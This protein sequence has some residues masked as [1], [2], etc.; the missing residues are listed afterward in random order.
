M[1]WGRVDAVQVMCWPFG[2][3]LVGVMLALLASS[4]AS[5]G[6]MTKETLAQA[7]PAPLIVGDKDT[8]LPVWPI[9]KQELTSTPLIG[10]AFES[11]D[12]APIPGFSGTPFNLLVALNAN[13]DFMDVQVLSQHEPVFLEGLGP[14]PMLRFVEQY[15]GLSLKQNIKIGGGQNNGGNAN[16]V[17]Q[18]VAKATASVRILNQ[19]LLSSSLK[20]A[21]SK[22]G[23]AQGRDPDLIAR[24]KPEV[25][26]NLDWDK[27][28]SKG[29]VSQRVFS[30]RMVNAAF[31]GT[32]AEDSDAE[33]RAAPDAVFETLYATPLHVPTIG[34]NL[35]SQRDWDYLQGRLE[36]GDS[37]LLVMAKGRYS[38]LGDEFTRGAV[39]SRITLR[40]GELPL[41]LRDLD[42]DL[43]EP[44]RVPDAL[45]DAEWKIFRVIAPAGLDPSLPLEFSLRVIRT[46]GEMYGERVGKD[47]MVKTELPDRYFEAAQSDNKTWHSLWM[48]RWWE[49]VVLAAGLAVLT[50]ALLK[51]T[52]LT[53]S[54]RRLN[55]F[56]T[57]YMLFT[58]GFIGW[59][60]QGQL[61]IVNLTG[62]VRALVEQRS[63]GFFLYDPMTVLLWAFT[64]VT[65]FVWGRGTFC[66]WLCPFGALQ[67]LIG[68][69]ARALKVPQIRL[70]VQT[71]S[72]LKKLKYLVLAVI[73]VSALV[74]V[75]WT[76]RLVE[77]EPFKTSITLLFVRSWPFVAWAVAL[78]VVNAVIY[79]SFCRYLCPLGAGMALLGR[80]RLQNWISR[81]TEC[82]QPCQRCANDCRYQSIK[83]SG[84]VDYVECFQCLDCVAIEQ[85]SDLCVPKILDKKRS[86][87]VIPIHP[88]KGA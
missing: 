65:F 71:D 42:I 80:L 54:M 66:G 79:K 78:L 52:W 38:M 10:Y 53:Q 17:I 14:E 86:T 40:Q 32:A 44:L 25:M 43:F 81:R 28:L 20:V 19:S 83:K 35:L 6:V 18:G 74:S 58:L 24:I 8:A 12:L 88:V 60:A 34:R 49:L 82:G 37:A 50:W 56:R 69:A 47:F 7:F 72:R 22:M 85:S 59:Y 77:V 39:P 27:L 11:I 61:S 31:A 67:E 75:T 41:E 76:D 57:A 68:N 21:R 45:K 29:L 55:R 15:K 30:N 62:V 87:V 5:A 1:V 64:A 23:Y 13:G 16:V 84:A 63:L 3:W 26:D 70:S 51:P 73:M 46:K 48:D 2:R 36:P 9:F 4:M 33:G